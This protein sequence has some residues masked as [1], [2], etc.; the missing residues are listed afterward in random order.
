MHNAIFVAFDEQHWHYA[1]HCFSS[2]RENYPLHPEILVYYKG[3]RKERIDWLK[4]QA[5]LKLFLNP[6]LP[7]D[8][9]A[10]KYHKDVLSDMVYYKY[11][12]WTDQFD[13]YDN[14]LHLDVD[15]LILSSLDELFEKHEFFIVKNNL[16]FKEIQVLDSNNGNRAA[17]DMR[18]YDVGLPFPQQGDMVNAGV[19]LIPKCYR[20][21]EYYSSL[22]YLTRVFSSYLKYADQSAISLWCMVHTIKPNEDYFYN[23]QMPLFNKFFIP[24]YKNTGSIFS[25][26]KNILNKIH[27]LHY[28][29]P[30]KPDHEKFMEWWLMGRYSK[31]F[32]K[33]YQRY[34]GV[35]L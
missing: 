21:P 22:L 24:R 35:V 25:F 29:G 26:K 18:L 15:T 10:S 34:E 11:L 7:K 3:F 17:I 31:L 8:L 9:I 16:Y 19:F 6:E 2:I 14:I 1:M 5:W 20:T 28:S 23:Y 32:K 12:L 30:L 27:I 13:K 4:R 33:C